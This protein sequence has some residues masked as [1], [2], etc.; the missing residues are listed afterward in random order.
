M[1]LNTLQS[2]RFTNRFAFFRIALL[3]EDKGILMI[4]I[5]TRII[6]KIMKKSYLLLSVYA[7][8]HNEETQ[9]EQI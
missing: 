6:S 5:V 7:V 4:P 1:K 8:C 9:N 2:I 3:S